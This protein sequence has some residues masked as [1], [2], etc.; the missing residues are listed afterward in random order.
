MLPSVPLQVVGLLVVPNAMVGAVG[1]ALM[2]TFPEAPE[3][4]P[5][6][7]ST[8]KVYVVDAANPAKV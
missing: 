1:C 4:Q 8:V 3:V 6:A 7:F 5:A 2:T